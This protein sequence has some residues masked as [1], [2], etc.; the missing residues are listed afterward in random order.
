M[1][2]TGKLILFCT[3]AY[4]GPAFAQMA[5]PADRHI[6]ITLQAEGRYDSNIARTSAAAAAVRGLTREDWRFT[7]SVA[8]DIGTPI[9]GRHSLT[10]VGSAGYDFHRHNKRLDRERIGVNST[11]GL[12]LSICNTSI[13]GGYTRRQ[14]ELGEIGAVGGGIQSVKNTETIRTIGS[15]VSCGRS[16]GFR[17]TASIQ[18]ENAD[19][20]NILRERTNRHALTYSGGVA[21]T[22]PSIGDL[23]VFVRRRETRFPDRPTLPGAG[24][25][26]YDVMSYGASYSRMIGTRLQGSVEATYT[27]VDKRGATTSGGSPNGINWAANLTATVSPRLQVHAVTSRAITSSLGI[28]SDYNKTS[29]YGIDGTFTLNPRVTLNAGYSFQN[30]KFFETQTGF[31]PALTKDRVHSLFGGATYALNDRVKF[32]FDVGR[33]SRAANGTFYDYTNTHAA[34]RVS[35]TF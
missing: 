15:T 3:A 22:H 5:A 30:R 7:P 21:Y 32:G 6:D 20:S 8:V 28:D 14:S 31:G 33:A 26:G 34:L 17:P 12:N 19:N 23:L 13:Q 9:G 27:D 4:S 16:F 24:D 18:Y 25:E 2:K 1:T 10:V 29:A 35:L 11:L